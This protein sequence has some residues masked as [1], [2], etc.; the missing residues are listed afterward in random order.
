MDLWT[1]LLSLLTGG[2]TDATATC[3]ADDTG[4]RTKMPPI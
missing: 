2:T 1:L 4:D 3:T